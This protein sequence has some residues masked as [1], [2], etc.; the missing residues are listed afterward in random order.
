MITI[1][2]II[3]AYNAERYI[4]E[5]LLS[6]L[7][8]TM[9][10]NEIIIVDD[11]SSDATVNTVMKLKKTSPV[12]LMLI[13]HG[14]NQGVSA[15]RNHGLAAASGEWILFMDADDVAEPNLLENAVTHWQKLQRESSQVWTVVYPAYAQINADSEA[16]PG[17]MRGA[18]LACRDVFGSQLVRNHLITPSG[19]MV[20][21]EA[22][23]KAGGFRL[24]LAHQVED[25][26]L[27]L[28]LAKAGGGFAYVDEPLVRVRRHP[29]NATKSMNKA[30][31]AELEI[32]AF[33]QLSEIRQA[34]FS[35]S[36]PRLKNITDFVGMLFKLGQWDDGYAVLQ[37][38]GTVEDGTVSF[39]MG[40]YW[41]KKEEPTMA[42]GFLEQTLRLNVQHG[43]AQN[44]LG[45]VYAVNGNLEAAICC[46]KNALKVLPE[47]MDAKANLEIVS[48][49]DVVQLCE[50]RITWR[51]LRPVLLSYSE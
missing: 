39:L 12:P 44:N 19:V 5:T 31:A 8:Q 50:L 7:R 1:S 27:W 41:L 42:R 2:A 48:R 17:V 51:E 25:W 26:D 38:E 10:L 35:R 45:V 46:W 37:Q 29:A 4:E 15:A 28:K 3:P 43:A 18:A 30:L 34:I 11:C 22:I 47:Y 9:P 33:Y 49:K 14:N 40:V 24:G 21:K 16:L 36:L 23:L 32:L 6:L 13:C 20:N